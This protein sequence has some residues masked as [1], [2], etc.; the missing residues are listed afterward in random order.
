MDA[1]RL[2]ADIIAQN[3]PVTAA[4][5]R[6]VAAYQTLFDCGYIEEAGVVQSIHCDDCG[7]PHDAEVAYLS[8]QY[9][10]HCPDLGFIAK[11][12]SELTAVK[13]NLRKLVE[14]LAD[15][16][17]C[18]RTKSTPIQDQTWRVGVVSGPSA[19]VA[20]YF[21]P[22]LRG[23]GDIRSLEAALAREAKSQLGIVLTAS[24]D[25]FRPP[26]KTLRIQDCL[27]FDE[28]TGAIECE[29]DLCATAGAP[30]KHKGGRPSPYKETLAKIITQRRDSRTALPGTNAEA[31]A[32]LG[33]LKLSMPS[34]PIPSISTIKKALAKV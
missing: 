16:L 4:Q 10:I 1:A 2:L 30:V 28:V 21:R 33:Q 32:I 18:K 7:Q 22:T 23:V 24:G 29:V 26:F 34:G 14:D 5:F 27:L 13:P 9:G 20:V 19:D 12:R 6:S 17:G 25:L 31:R 3:V 11:Q 8:G 15:C